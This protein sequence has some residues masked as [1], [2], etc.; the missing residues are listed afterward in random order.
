MRCPHCAVE[1]HPD[2]AE[3]TITP[4]SSKSTFEEYEENMDP[5]R[6]FRIE[7]VWLWEAME[8]PACSKVIINVAIVDVD[9]PIYRTAYLAYPPF[10]KRKLIEGSIPEKVRADYVE[11]CN[12]LPASAK[13]SAALSRRVLQAILNDQGYIA[14]DLAKQVALAMDEDDADKRLP[15]SIR[16]TVDAVRNFGNFAAHPITDASG[17]HII[18]VEPTEAKWCLEIIE[19]LFEHY[20]GDELDERVANLQAKLASANKPNRLS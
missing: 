15:S 14:D 20:Y 13:A 10:P 3:G 6:T 9:H 11:A 2:W 17:L 16:K 5:R 4:K 7:T 18:D 12:V 1:I 8:C 19:A